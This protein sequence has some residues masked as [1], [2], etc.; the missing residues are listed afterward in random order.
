MNPTYC[1]FILEPKH[2][3]CIII[4]YKGGT[5]EIVPGSKFGRGYLCPPTSPKTSPAALPTG[6]HLGTVTDLYTIPIEKINNV[7]QI[8]RLYN[9]KPFNSSDKKCRKLMKMHTSFIFF[10][11]EKPRTLALALCAFFFTT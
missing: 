5:D 7:S 8:S 1:R 9:S 4:F 11:G 3:P 6:R 10:P 2:F